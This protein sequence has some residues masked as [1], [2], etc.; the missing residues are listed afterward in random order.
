ME[1]VN[2]G[3]GACSIDT[4]AA[5]LAGLIGLRPDLVVL[6][7]VTNDIR[8]I[9]DKRREDLVSFKS[10]PPAGRAERK[11]TGP[12]R[13]TQWL[14]VH[15]ALGEIVLDS[16][17]H[18]RFASY[19][20]SEKSD[21]PAQLTPERYR[22]DGG[23]DYADNAAFFLQYYASSDGIVLQRPL[24]AHTLSLVDNYLFALDRVAAFCRHHDATLMLV[25]FPCYPQVYDPS[26]SMEMRD[27]LERASTKLAIPFLDLTPAFREAGR[28]QV[29]HLAPVD[30][31][32]N[33]D[34]NGVMARAIADF[35][36]AEHLL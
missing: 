25:Y 1:V 3:M 34:G 28:A 12:S 17:L 4:E 27:I 29:L 31:H 15:S 22:I 5:T 9:Q 6:T 11:L 18:L 2:A 13:L 7:F 24:S 36:A 33:P 32:P 35:L 19:R 30:F 14:V 8:E 16:Y 23:D 26:S 20:A 21:V 10:P